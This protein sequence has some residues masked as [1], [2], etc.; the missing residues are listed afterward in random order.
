MNVP[1]LMPY[2]DQ[3]FNGDNYVC[4]EFLR[5]KEKYQ[6]NLAV[7]TGSCLYSTTLWLAQNFNSVQTVEINKD[8]ASFG[9]YK[10]ADYPNVRPWI[11][12]SVEFL[13][14]LSTLLA[15]SDKILYF[16]DAHWNEHCPLLH[17]LAAISKIKTTQPPIIVI[18]DFYTGDPNLGWDEY[19]GQD[20]DYQWIEPSI[21]NLESSFNCIYEHYYNTQA[22]GA[23][24]GLIYI[25]PKL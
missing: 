6:I 25:I 4:Q 24:R 16:L 10:I 22:E 8:F 21:K 12:D 23:K 13:N 11:C 18:H 9:Q 15:P 5:L 1:L 7:E 20:F 19:D 2:Q 17:E 3:P 14:M